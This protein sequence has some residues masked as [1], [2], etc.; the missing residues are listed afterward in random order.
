MAR[1]SAARIVLRKDGDALSTAEHLGFTLLLF[2]AAFVIALSV[3][4]LDTILGFVGAT[5]GM[6]IGFLFPAWIYYKLR[7][8]TTSQAQLAG[9]QLLQNRP[10]DASSKNQSR[11]GAGVVIVLSGVLVPVLVGVQLYQARQ[12]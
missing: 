11:F 12:T 8:K 5:V 2:S 4:D 6:C 9:G 1:G 3:K 10:Y 7:N